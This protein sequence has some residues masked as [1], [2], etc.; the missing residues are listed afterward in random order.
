MPELC[1]EELKIKQVDIT[2]TLL[3]PDEVVNLDCVIDCK[4][5][6]KLST[7]LR[8]TAYVIKFVRILKC[9][10]KKVEA[11][12]TELSAADKAEA[13]TRSTRPSE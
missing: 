3:N 6:S 1:R 4:S 2:H 10:I 7:L 11:A 13:E 5:Y 12:S 9:K 8:V